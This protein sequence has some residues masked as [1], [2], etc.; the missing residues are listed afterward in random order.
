MLSAQ[1]SRLNTSSD[2]LGRCPLGANQKLLGV[3]WSWVVKQAYRT[4]VQSEILKHVE[5][6]IIRL[7]Q[8]RWCVVG[9]A[10]PDGLKQTVQIV[11]PGGKDPLDAGVCLG[12]SA[13]K[14]QE[15]GWD[16]LGG[17]AG[18]SPEGCCIFFQR[19]L[20]KEGKVAGTW[21]WSSNP[22]RISLNGSFGFGVGGFES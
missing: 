18:W 1:A 22:L 2:T 5:I 13:Q 14:P 8:F 10:V 19:Y 21:F 4:F 6:C 15:T 9:K 17:G 11:L 3:G 20:L 12:G 7:P 16:C